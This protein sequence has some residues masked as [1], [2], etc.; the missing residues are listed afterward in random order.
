MTGLWGDHPTIYDDLTSLY[1]LSVYNSTYWSDGILPLFQ[2]MVPETARPYFGQLSSII[3]DFSIKCPSWFAAVGN[4]IAGA[5]TWKLFFDAGTKLHVATENYL[6]G[7]SGSTF[8]P[9]LEYLMKNYFISFFI[10][11]DPNKVVSGLEAAPAIRPTWLEYKGSVPQGS[12]GYYQQETKPKPQVLHLRDKSIDTMD[13]PDD[14]E[15]C[16]FF[17]SNARSVFHI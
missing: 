4:S 10:N 15:K 6:I 16:R 17:V 7:T 8:N 3:G 14:N 12:S 1:P 13:D 11:M 5:P 2:A 9:Q